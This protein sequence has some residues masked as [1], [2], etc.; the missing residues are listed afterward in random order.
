MRF[1]GGRATLLAVALAVA[2]GRAMAAEDGGTAG[3]GSG[4]GGGA[5]ATSGTTAPASRDTTGDDSAFSDLFSAVEEVRSGER[6]WL[7]PGTA[8][9]SV[10]FIYTAQKWD[11]SFDVLTGPGTVERLSTNTSNRLA[12]E[13]FTARYERFAVLAPQLV[14][15]TFSI[16]GGLQQNRSNTN[17]QS[18]GE[19]GTLLGYEL[20]LSILEESSYPGSV[21]ANRD[22]STTTLPFGGTQEVHTENRGITWRMLDT[23]FLRQREI[24]PFFSAS[25]QAYQ[26]RTE[27]T[28]SLAG[29]SAH[30]DNDRSV[31]RLAADN[32]TETSDLAF[33]YLFTRFTNRYGAT[34][35]YQDQ[36]ALL[37]Y[38]LDFGPN[39]TWQWVSDMQY[40][41][42]TGTDQSKLSNVSVQQTLSINHN[43]AVYSSY[44]YSF[45]RQEDSGFGALTAQTGS[46]QLQYT[47]FNN[48]TTWITGSGTTRDLT[49]GSFSAG[50][51]QLY[52]S[53]WRPIPWYG[54]VNA[55]GG[56]S[57]LISDTNVPG[58]AAPVI[59]AAYV[60]PASFGQDQQILLRELFVVAASI[61][62]VVIKKDGTRLTAKEGTDYIVVPVGYRTYIQ[63]LTTSLVI[64][65]LDP[66]RISYLYDVPPHLRYRTTTRNATL[67]GAWPYISLTYNHTESDSVPLAGGDSS[68]LVSLRSDE[69]DVSFKGEWGPIQA[70][71]DARLYRFDSMG[72]SYKRLS[73]SEFLGYTPYPDFSCQL[74]ATQYALDYD[75]PA[76]SSRGQSWQLALT[77]ARGYWT[78]Y[79]YAL[80]R[81]VTDS[82]LPTETYREAGVKINGQRGKLSGGLVLF[83]NQR[84][85]AGTESRGLGG[86]VNV[87]REF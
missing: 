73:A 27:T 51:V 52:A 5:S 64:Q 72:L 75:F 83:A 55:S 71:A 13:Y 56:Y 43:S 50:G 15:G 66:L 32:G 86:Q 39:R 87:V 82:L 29:Q 2:A 6:P 41:L 59:D 68:Q 48:F 37:N 35:S 84:S 36:N 74:T 10:G 20:A 49:N 31:V 63:P 17:G 14:N 45:N 40:S 9:G 58:G 28:T 60:A 33:R 78:S 7:L 8:R 34:Y 42:N 30:R 47:P 54:S 85:Y 46:A 16:L 53:Y 3:K 38:S 61:R 26:E 18:T 12:S 67:G 57:Y 25:L 76:R 1:A 21:Y 79:A 4:P 11:S 62:V 23:G 22:L 44:F 81:V 77:Y 24:L 65:P 19:N 69:L 80:Q 70:R